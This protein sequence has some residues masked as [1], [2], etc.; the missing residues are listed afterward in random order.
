MLPQLDVGMRVVREAFVK[1]E[2]RAGGIG[3]NER[4]GGE[5]HADADDVVG[6]DPAGFQQFGND[7]IECI[8]VVLRMLESKIRRE[9]DGAVRR[10]KRFVHDGV[11]VI[12]HG[13][14][15][16]ASVGGSYQKRTGGKGPEVETDGIGCSFHGEF[17][18]F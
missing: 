8:K 14:A 13:R 12:E 5:I 2:G 3:R 9:L 10:E 4:A 1:A 16:L 7:V 17:L 15:D 18:W 6:G 11:R